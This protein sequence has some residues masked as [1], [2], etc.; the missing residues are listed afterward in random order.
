MRLQ[1]EHGLHDGDGGVEILIRDGD[2]IDAANSSL[3]RPPSFAVAPNTSRVQ[4]S[5][6]VT[7]AATATCAA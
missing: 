2:V 7:R 4:I 6:T 3:T 5:P 1:S